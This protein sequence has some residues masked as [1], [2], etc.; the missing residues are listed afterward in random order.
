MTV[1]LTQYGVEQLQRRSGASQ[2]VLR[3]MEIAHGGRHMAVPHQTLDGMNIHTG[4]QQVRGEA[5]ASM[6]M[7]A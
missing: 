4:F 2:L 3:Q 5:V 7:S 6:P 1:R